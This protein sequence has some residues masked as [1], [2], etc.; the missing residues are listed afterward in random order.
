MIVYVIKT[1]KNLYLTKT[2]SGV[3]WVKFL[4]QAK[5]YKNETNAR[6]VMEEVKSNGCS[7]LYGTE[8]SIVKVAIDE[9]DE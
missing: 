5:L 6:K 2:Y 1:D 8:F 3:K 4:Y 7:V 9:A